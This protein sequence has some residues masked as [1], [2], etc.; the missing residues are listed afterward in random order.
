[1]L[2]ESHPSA[3]ILTVDTMILNLRIVCSIGEEGVENVKPRFPFPENEYMLD[4]SSVSLKSP[5][6]L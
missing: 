2:G 5:S 6:L 3:P 1:M 4:A